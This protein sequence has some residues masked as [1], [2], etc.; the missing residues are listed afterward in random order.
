MTV[1]PENIETAY[2]HWLEGTKRYEHRSDL[3]RFIKFVEACA[4]DPR[5]APSTHDFEKRLRQDHNDPDGIH[6]PVIEKHRC[7]YSGIRAYLEY[8]RGEQQIRRPQRR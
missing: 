2:Q 4:D 3:G 5:N 7:W 6:A 8:K 1:W